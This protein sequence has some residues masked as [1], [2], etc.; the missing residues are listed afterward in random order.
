MLSSMKRLKH[1]VVRIAGTY[2]VVVDGPYGSEGDFVLSCTAVDISC[3]TCV[4]NS[5]DSNCDGIVD[6]LDVVAL[7]NHLTE[8]VLLSECEALAAD[9]DADG[10]LNVLD[11]VVM[12]KLITGG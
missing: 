4:A 1:E 8:K 10:V 7:L 5:M 3:A 11:A 2:I 12:I 6:I 9:A